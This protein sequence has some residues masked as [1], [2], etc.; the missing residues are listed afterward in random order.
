MKVI[1]GAII[2][3]VIVFMLLLGIAVPAA[4]IGLAVFLI[5]LYLNNQ[6]RKYKINFKKSG[7]IMAAGFVLS[8]FLATADSNAT[9]TGSE[10]EK[11]QIMTDQ[12]EADKKA[13]EEKLAEE[14]A[15]EEEAKMQAEEQERLEEEQEEKQKQE[16]AE[17]QKQVQDQNQAA[18]SLGLE[19][20]TVGRVV[21]GD[22]I[23][24]SDGRKVRLIGVNTPESTTRVEEYGIEASQFTASE[25]TGKKIWMQKDVSDTD[26][27]GRLLRI[28]WVDIPT[29]DMDEN[30]IRE[31]MFNAHLVLNGY[32]EPSTYNPDVKYSDYFRKFG[33][34]ARE[35]TKGLW[36]LGDEGTTK[37]DLDSAAASGSSSGSGNA[38][39][40][41][42]N[43]SSGTAAN[44]SSAE[45]S[46]ESY[47]NCTELRKVYPNGVPSTHPAYDSKHDRDKDNFACER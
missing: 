20:V 40:S 4:L 7:W 9:E 15:K 11:E 45:G 44:S 19:L 36:A 5:G 6:Y 18:E 42:S 24:T 17:K 37:G 23:E 25:L 13:E 2:T 16:E 38:G 21:D 46:T 3:I 39:G 31:K 22:T 26:R 8:I 12:D 47:Q 32:A 10:P 43:D 29:D 28:I 27:Y 34:E 1:R 30:E 33:R 41:G 35:A 14:K